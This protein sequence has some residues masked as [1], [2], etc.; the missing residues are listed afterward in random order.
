[1]C[2]YLDKGNNAALKQANIVAMIN[3]QANWSSSKQMNVHTNNR[4]YLTWCGKWSV[5]WHGAPR[6]SLIFLL[7]VVAWRLLG[8]GVPRAPTAEGV[9]GLFATLH[10]D[11]SLKNMIF[12]C[13]A[14]GCTLPG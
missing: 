4:T 2:L 6:E 12:R 13:R 7:P 5:Q 9:G 3:N 14:H 10:C 11:K 1:M 8:P